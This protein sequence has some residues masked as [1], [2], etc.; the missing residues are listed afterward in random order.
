MFKS[1][2]GL[3][4]MFVWIGGAVLG[5]LMNFS[6]D[7]DGGGDSS[8]ALENFLDTGAN[9]ETIKIDTPGAGSR[10]TRSPR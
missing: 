4:L 9:I 3:V 2:F 7:L 5:S 8:S 10:P 6:V 1:G